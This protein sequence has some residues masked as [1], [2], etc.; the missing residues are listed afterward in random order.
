MSRK[1][2]HHDEEE[3]VAGCD[4]CR[5]WHTN[6]RHRAGIIA[7]RESTPKEGGKRGVI[8]QTPALKPECKFLG[9]IVEPCTSPCGSE[10]AA[11][12]VHRCDHDD[13]PDKCRRGE[14]ADPEAVRSCADCPLYEPAGKSL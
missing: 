7:A 2:C 5:R 13:G 11:K 9:P 6:P 8:V 4:E 3:Q 10:R 14:T 12:N 1:F